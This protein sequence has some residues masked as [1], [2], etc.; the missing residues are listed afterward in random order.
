VRSHTMRESVK[1]D[2]GILN[3]VLVPMTSARF[4]ASSARSLHAALLR[5]LE[6]IDPD[7]SR[8]L[9]DS[10]IGA[11]STDH[12]LV[13]SGLCSSPDSAGGEAFVEEGCTYSASI[14]ALTH[15]VTQALDLA[16]CPQHPL[17]QE[18][19]I[20]EHVPFAVILEDTYWH[21]LCTY[22]SLLTAA[23]PRRGIALEFCSPTG[24]RTR[25]KSPALPEPTICISGYLRKW[26]A[27]SP[28]TLPD[29]LLMGY[30]RKCMTLNTYSLMPAVQRFGE[31]IERGFIGR[32]EWHAKGS[33]PSLLRQVNALVE[34][35][36]YCGTGMKTALG[37]GQ[38]R[39][40]R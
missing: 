31:Y 17:G 8:R 29:E 14:T 39:R 5:R 19:L 40:I 34:F 16:F 25:S 26:N 20:L 12:P 22:A 9:H 15:E 21:S 3:L 33:S 38:T 4:H 24:F 37:M 6:L 28:V 36:C 30:V 11:H 1:P 23:N 18:P 27:F 10:Q 35:S 32:V 7:L 2:I 13:V